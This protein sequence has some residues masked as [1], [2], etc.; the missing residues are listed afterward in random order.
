MDHYFYEEHKLCNL[1]TMDAQMIAI[2]KGCLT[3]EA[4]NHLT[5]HN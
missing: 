1:F 5:E 2:C 3:K 4:S